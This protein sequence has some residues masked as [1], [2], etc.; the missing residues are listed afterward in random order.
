MKSAKYHLK[1][2]MGNSLLT[3]KELFTL[4]T[5]IDAIL[6]SRHLTPLSA[7]SLNLPPLTPS[8]L[9]VGRSLT[10]V[11]DPSLLHLHLGRLSR[12]QQIQQMQQNFWAHCSKEYISELQG[13][14]KWN[15]E[16]HNVREGTR[17]LNSPPMQWRMG[18][19]SKLHLG[20]D[21]IV[22]V[23]TLRTKGDLIRRAVARLCPL[24]S[25]PEKGS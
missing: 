22:R 3:F 2:V 9:L 18:L 20:K 17:L 1:R 5:Q 19:V 21:G 12:H 23:I 25:Q 8:H 24:P 14:V 15:K 6:N 4:L 11:P 16:Q 10:A 7:D 13:R